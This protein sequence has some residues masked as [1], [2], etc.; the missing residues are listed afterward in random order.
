MKPV[1]LKYND[2]IYNFLY[3]QNYQNINRS[4]LNFDLHLLPPNQG[5]TNDFIVIPSFPSVS[6]YL[7]PL[8]RVFH[9][10]VLTP[11]WG[12]NTRTN[13]LAVLSIGARFVALSQTVCG[14]KP[15]GPQLWIRSDSSL[16]RS[17]RSAQRG[18]TVREGVESFASSR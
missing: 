12:P 13:H 10:K 18:R 5:T 3:S 6:Y 1:D 8:E 16:H 7:I 17:G 2:E 15:D 4:I 11:I 9:S 14:F